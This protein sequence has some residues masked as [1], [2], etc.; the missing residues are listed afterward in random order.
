MTVWQ[1]SPRKLPQNSRVQ[2]GHPVRKN[3][4]EIVY[5]KLRSHLANDTPRNTFPE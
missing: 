3:A 1:S 5:Y 2:P 4:I